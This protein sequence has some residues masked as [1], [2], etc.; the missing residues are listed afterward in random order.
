M[1][2]QE[3]KLQAFKRSLSS[4]DMTEGR[5]WKKLLLFTV[6]LLIGNI[7]QQMYSTADALILGQVI[8]DGALA[9]VGA[10]IPIFFFIIVLMMGIAMG[11]GVVVSQY[12]GAKKRE[13]LSYTIGAA[14]TLTTILGVVIM[15]LGPLATRPRSRHAGSAR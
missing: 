4:I 12:F 14:I 1:T 9:A 5:P 2:Q 8:G 11:A 3:G 10:S 15:V 13:E 6:P 7:F